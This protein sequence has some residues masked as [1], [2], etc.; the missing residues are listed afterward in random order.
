MSTSKTSGAGGGREEQRARALIRDLGQSFE[1][2]IA[3]EQS[4]RRGKN[5]VSGMPGETIVAGRGAVCG[6]W[7]GA[8]WG[9][10]QGILAPRR[11]KFEYGRIVSAGDEGRAVLV[12]V[13]AV[14]SRLV[15][16]SRA[17]SGLT[18]ACWERLLHL[19]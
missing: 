11:L 17:V 10:F 16:V 15:G 5:G 4:G 12:V 6:D 2:S 3:V 18:V 9:G 8:T 1:S 19:F 14:L 13:V 7:Q